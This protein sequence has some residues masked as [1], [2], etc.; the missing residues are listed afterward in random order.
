MADVSEALVRSVLQEVMSRLGGSP[1]AA[2]A[3]GGGVA[4]KSYAGRYGVFEDPREEI[5]RAHV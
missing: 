1:S 3:V 4:P 2:S 5:G